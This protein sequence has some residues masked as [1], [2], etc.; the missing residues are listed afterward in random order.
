MNKDWSKL[1]QSANQ[2]PTND[3]LLPYVLEVLKNGEEATNHVIRNRVYDFLSIPEEIKNI[4]YPNYPDD[5]GILANRFSFS[6]SKLYKAKARHL[7]DYRSRTTLVDTIRR[8]TYRK[9]TRRGT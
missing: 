1:K 3:S 2:I 7:S 8:S 9:G 6:L 4:K 5:D